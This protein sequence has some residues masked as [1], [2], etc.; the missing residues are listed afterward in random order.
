MCLWYV[1]LIAANLVCD[2]ATLQMGIGNIP[3]A[4]LAALKNHK[5]QP[6]AEAASTNCH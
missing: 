2:G 3:N 5:V 6:S 1:S 4:T